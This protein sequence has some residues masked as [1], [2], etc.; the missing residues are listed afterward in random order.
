[1]AF[2][3]L[4]VDDSRVTR[5]MID[6]T[7]RLAEVDVGEMYQAANGQEALDVMAEHWVDLV[8]ADINMPVMT[9][10]ELIAKMSENEAMKSIPVVVVTTEGS[11]TRI[12]ELRQKG[13][14]AY[15]RKPFQPEELAT[16]VH[17]VLGTPHA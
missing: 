16:A 7:I 4:I 9:G 1:M 8:F 11:S 10:M 12:E 13:V 17:Q 2:N 15:L 14:A 6:K 3:I 5:A